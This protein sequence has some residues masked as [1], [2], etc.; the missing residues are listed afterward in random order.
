VSLFSIVRQQAQFD[1]F[2]CST[3]QLAVTGDYNRGYYGSFPE[4]V[5]NFQKTT[6][7]RLW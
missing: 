7:S 1:S 2:N 6:F 3:L 4:E 5:K